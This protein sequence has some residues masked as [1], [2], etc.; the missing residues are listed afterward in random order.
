MTPASILEFTATGPASRLAGAIEQ[1][2]QGR[3]ALHVLV[4]PWESE[5]G[6]VNMALTSVNRDG[7][8]IEHTN[9]GTI[10]LTD[11]DQSLTRVAVIA[12]ASGHPDHEKLTRVLRDFAAQLHTQF[13]APQTA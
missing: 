1:Y 12:E 9:L 2:V 3:G 13:Q 10:T 4:V 11:L 7:W 6:R 8:A 5:P